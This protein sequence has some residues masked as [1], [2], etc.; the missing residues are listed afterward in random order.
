M[1]CSDVRSLISF[2]IF[3]SM[4]NCQIVVSCNNHKSN[5]TAH[6]KYI[7]N[8]LNTNI[9]SYIETSRGQSSNLYL[10][11]A[12]FVH[13]NVNYISV[14]A[15]NNYSP[16]LVSNMFCSIDVLYSHWVPVYG[17]NAFLESDC[18][19]C[20]WL[21]KVDWQTKR[22]SDDQKMFLRMFWSISV[23]KEKKKIIWLNEWYKTRMELSKF[24]AII[25]TSNYDKVALTA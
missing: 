19:N 8:D 23:M 7:N 13:T 25:V 5:G 3:Q 24:L 20:E 17:L 4:R 11:V 22:F 6:F 9:Y 2:L 12:L 16:A 14:A 21:V 15:Q 10:N 1:F 18:N